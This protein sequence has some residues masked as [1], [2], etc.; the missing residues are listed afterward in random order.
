MLEGAAPSAPI[1]PARQRRG[2]LFKNVARLHPAKIGRHGGRPSSIPTNAARKRLS[3]TL[4]GD[5]PSAPIFPACQ[6]GLVGWN[7]AGLR[8][9][10]VGRHGGRPCSITTNAA[11]KRLSKTLE[12]DAPSA[13][14]F[15]ACQRGL[16]G[17][18]GAGLRPAKVGRHGGRP[19]S[20]RNAYGL[21]ALRLRL[22][23]RHP[24]GS[25]ILQTSS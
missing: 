3:K 21:P 23:A 6:R 14:I 20:E 25:F 5:A 24:F 19:S 12:G 13:P 9:A 16:V 11:R 22:Q 1:F 18:M 17:W 2:G 8:P 4:E 10:K 7:E 15:P